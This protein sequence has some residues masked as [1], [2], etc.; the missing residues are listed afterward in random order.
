MNYKSLGK[1][2]FRV[3]S[4]VDSIIVDLINEIDEKNDEIG[5]AVLFDLSSR[6]TPCLIELYNFD[7]TVAEFSLNLKS[8]YPEH[9]V[10]PRFNG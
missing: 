2:R 8:Q 1:V 10:P 5:S 4:L 7:Q 6:L 3:K 9:P